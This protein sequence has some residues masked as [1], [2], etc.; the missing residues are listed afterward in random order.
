V[1]ASS[2]ALT[3]GS[4]PKFDLIA[5]NV[6]FRNQPAALVWDGTG[7]GIRFVANHCGKSVPAGLCH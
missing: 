5:R 2:H 6:A 4:D 7:A 1:V 3:K